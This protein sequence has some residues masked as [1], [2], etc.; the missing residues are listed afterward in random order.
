MVS[1]NRERK[2]RIKARLAAPEGVRWDRVRGSSREGVAI[3]FLLGGVEGWVYLPFYGIFFDDGNV[4]RDR[5]L[6][7]GFKD[8][9]K[10]SQSLQMPWFMSAKPQ[11]GETRNFDGQT[12]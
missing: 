12:T 5:C 10:L 7:L 3:R 9:L 11:D 4:R 6:L 8:A 1:R 2:Y